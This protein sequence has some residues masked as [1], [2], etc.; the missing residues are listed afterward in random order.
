MFVTFGSPLG[1][2]HG[3]D[4]A[5]LDK[6]EKRLGVSIPESLRAYYEI[7]GNER[8]FNRSMQRFLSPSNWFID[9]KQLVFLDENQ[10]V[11]QWGVSIKSKGAKDP[12]V[13]KGIDHGDDTEWHKEH[14][15]CS[16]F[17]S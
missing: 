16:I 4:A 5:I 9:Q 6:A 11:C 2:S 7:A 14:N 8:K 15:Q 1:K 3:V 13:S 12:K 17:I 10:S